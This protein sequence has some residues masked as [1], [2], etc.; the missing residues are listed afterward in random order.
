MKVELDKVM[1]IIKD[2]FNN[3]Q[4]ICDVLESEFDKLEYGEVTECANC[5]KTIY[6]S[7]YLHRY[8]HID[9]EIFCD[10]NSLWDDNITIDNLDKIAVPKQKSDK[11]E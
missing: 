6:F 4:A 1:E 10:A 7:S 11:K 2:N 9:N 3:G 8:C 5:G